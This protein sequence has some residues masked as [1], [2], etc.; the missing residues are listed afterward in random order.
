MGK[1]DSTDKAGQ[2]EERKRE[3]ACRQVAKKSDYSDKSVCVYCSR[4]Y[5]FQELNKTHTICK[6]NN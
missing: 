5:T 2:Y 1:R 3:R 4:Y 6:R